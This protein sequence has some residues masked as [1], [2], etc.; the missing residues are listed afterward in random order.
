MAN[1]FNVN[2]YIHLLLVLI[3]VFLTFISY[4]FTIAIMNIFSLFTTEVE[5]RGLG[6]GYFMVT[7]NNNNNSFIYLIIIIL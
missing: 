7:Y 5:D 3:L 6:I 1:I 2:L 4:F